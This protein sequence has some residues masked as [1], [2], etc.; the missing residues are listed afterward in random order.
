MVGNYNLQNPLR[1]RQE[2]I[3]DNLYGA[4]RR[5]ANLPKKDTKGNVFFGPERPPQPSK[6]R[7]VGAVNV[8]GENFTAR[9]VLDRFPHLRGFL[10]KF[11]KN[12]YV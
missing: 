12:P 10:R 3:Q 4:H 6:R 8:N 11:R 5:R 9:Q 1:Q 2:E 7:R